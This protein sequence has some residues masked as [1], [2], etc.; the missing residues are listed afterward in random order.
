MIRMF[1]RNWWTF[2]GRGLFAI[3]FG[4]LALALPEL[5]LIVMIW[6]FGG[7]IIAD[8]LFQ[9]VYAITRRKEFQR[10]WLL[11]LEGIF[12]LALGVITFV[13]PGITGIAL[14]MMIVAWAI[15]T[16][17]L[18]IAAAI[19]LRRILENEWLL[20]FS[21]ILSILLGIAMLVWPGASV[22]ALAWMIGIY[23]IAFGITLILLGFRLKNWDPKSSHAPA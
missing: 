9:I 3:L 14:F 13:W 5:T 6:M 20:A 10:W 23:A 11:L 4:T 16:G 18:E 7:Y 17:V 22:L 15:V 8:G 2:L 12:S 21:G 19:Q 1:S